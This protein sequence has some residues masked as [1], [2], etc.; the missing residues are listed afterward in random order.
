MPQRRTVAKDKQLAPESREV[1]SLSLEGTSGPLSVD[2][3]YQIEKHNLRVKQWRE[4]P[5][6]TGLTEPTWYDES[7]KPCKLSRGYGDSEL[8]RDHTGCL[9]FSAWVC[10]RLGADRLGNMTVLKSSEELVEEITVDEESGEIISR[11]YTRPVIQVIVGPFWPMLIFI[12]YPLIFGA[13]WY[14]FKLISKGGLPI[15]LVFVWALCTV[16]LIIS[17]A[18]TA[19]SDPGILYKHPKAPPQ[20]ENTWRWTDQAMSYRPRRAHYDPD[21]AVVVEEFDH[22]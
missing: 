18:L 10:S 15:A 12:T 19:F 9:C 13:S 3:Q 20:E 7:R 17:L 1:K 16:S 8:E 6:A 14:T 22:T 21:C 5:F 4:S 2:E 11:T